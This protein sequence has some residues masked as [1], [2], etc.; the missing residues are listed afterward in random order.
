MSARAFVVKYA[1]A[2][3]RARAYT[4]AHAAS[5]EHARREAD[6]W[7]AGGAWGGIPQDELRVWVD[8]AGRVVYGEP[9]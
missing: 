3:R 9:A 6:A 1:R 4:H 2:G 5:L 7:L 8:A